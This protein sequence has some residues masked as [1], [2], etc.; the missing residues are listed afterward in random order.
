MTSVAGLVPRNIRAFKVKVGTY[1]CMYAYVCICVLCVYF[2]CA[3]VHVSFH[4]L[5]FCS[6]F[7]V[8]IDMYGR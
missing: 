2:I 1:V 6:V 4:V 3:Q 5:Y 7:S 8:G